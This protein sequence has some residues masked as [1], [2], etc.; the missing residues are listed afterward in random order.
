[1][2]QKEN[3][4]PVMVFVNIVKDYLPNNGSVLEIG[5]WKGE[6]TCAYLNIIKEK[7]SKSYI[8]DWF[9]GNK[10]Y[11]ANAPHGWLYEDKSYVR[12]CL[13]KNIEEI[14]CSDIVTIIEGDSLIVIEQIPDESLD[15][16]FIDGGHQY[17]IVIKDLN[18]SYKKLKTNGILCGHDFNHDGVRMAV[19][20]FSKQKSLKYEI[21]ED[22]MGQKQPV[23]IFDRK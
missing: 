2:T 1:M 12:Q 11:V 17:D 5:T 20:E 14:G 3:H 6:T 18:N 10:E 16:I 4:P 13:E 7:K 19:E 9:N 8:I 22:P 23:Y 15:I 21:L